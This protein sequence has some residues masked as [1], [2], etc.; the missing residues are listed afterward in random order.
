MGAF[1][2]HHDSID[3]QFA[4]GDI[5]EYDF[6]AW[7]DSFFTPIEAPEDMGASLGD[8]ELDDFG[9]SDPDQHGPDRGDVTLEDFLD[10]D[11]AY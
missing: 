5:G 11:D 9:Y 4:N 1:Y 10:G 6:S 7:E 2:P 8:M 3:V